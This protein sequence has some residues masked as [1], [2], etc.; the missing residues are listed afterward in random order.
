MDRLLER[1]NEKR[2]VQSD[3]YVSLDP[4]RQH[5]QDAYVDAMNSRGFETNGSFAQAD[6]AQE[7]NPD[8]FA[9]SD[10]AT[11]AYNAPSADPYAQ[12]GQDRENF[13]MRN[14]NSYYAPQEAVSAIPQTENREQTYAYVQPTR[15]GTGLESGVYHSENVRTKKRQKLSARTKMCFAVYFFIVLVSMTLLLIN[16]AGANTQALAEQPQ[17]PQLDTSAVNYVV[18]QDGSVTQIE[19]NAPVI[20]FEEERQTNWFD[21]M[22]DEF[23]KLLK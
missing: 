2:A 15:F 23:S 18:N 10:Y 20:V 4:Y 3:A 9:Q 6:Y 22:C 17:Q 7:Y 14:A 1:E 21:N 13:G 8:P 19:D 11:P 5:R 16:I 12:Y